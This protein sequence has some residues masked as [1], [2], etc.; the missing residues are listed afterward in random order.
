MRRYPHPNPPPLSRERESYCSGLP[1][2]RSGWGGGRRLRIAAVV[3]LAAA[4]AGCEVG[5]NYHTPQPDVPADFVQTGASAAPP[6]DLTHWW[7][8]FKDPELTSLVQ[9]AIAANLDLRIALARLQEARTEESVVVGGALPE[10]DASGALARGTGSDAARGRADEPLVAADN[11]HGGRINQVVGFDADW[12]I[13][14]FGKLRREIEAAG[15]DAQAA[16]AARN[17]TLVAVVGD[18]ARSYFDLRGLQM[19]LAVLDRSIATAQQTSDLV[20]ARYQRGFTNE[21]DAELAARELATLQA[22]RP[23]LTA[24]IDAARYG[25]AVLLGGQ[26]QSLDAELGKPGEIPAL[27]AGISAGLPLDLLKRRP[28]IAEAERQLAASTARVGVATA[29]LFPSLSLT[30]AVG[31]QGLAGT[32]AKSNPLIWAAGPATSWSILDFGTLDA[33][34]DV[35]D[36]RSREFLLDYRQTVL[37]AVRDVDTALKDY[38]ARQQELA[39][40]AD[41]LAA[42]RKAVD[43]AGARYD[44]GL[45]DFLNALDAQR[46]EYALEDQFATAEQKAA[47]SLVTLYKNLGGGWESY[48][49]VP[50]APH[51]QPAVL[52]AMRRLVD[53]SRATE[54]SDTP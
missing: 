16:A 48:Q 14:L 7:E 12:E 32:A 4:L 24:R 1:L 47:D 38:A 9:R 31:W 35:A 51:P 23:P 41:A 6:A 39:H 22:E 34:V 50:D 18:V 40:L 27:P 19:R 53:P 21:L 25:L 54:G 49:S 43:L 3:L 15:A 8:S 26:P 29:D 17:D 37:D 30:G 2:P 5:P 44:R 52:A 10:V 42:S 13:D 28:D 45:T 46:Q 33:Q 20:G 11:A 36:L